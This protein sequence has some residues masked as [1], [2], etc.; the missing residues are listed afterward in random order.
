[1]TGPLG[2][3]YSMGRFTVEQVAA[4]KPGH[5]VLSQYPDGTVELGCKVA[6]RWQ[7]SPL[8]RLSCHPHLPSMLDTIIT[9]S[10]LP[11]VGVSRFD[12]HCTL[13][14]VDRHLCPGCGDPTPHVLRNQVEVC[15]ACRLRL[16][17]ERGP[18][19]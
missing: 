8:G 3:S 18:G 2:C 9:R 19:R 10:G 11:T 17:A 1:M 4:R 12:A 6:P 15:P 16:D 14:D 13:C 7:L 5:R